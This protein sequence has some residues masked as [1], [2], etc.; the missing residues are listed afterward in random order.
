[1]LCY[2]GDPAWE[3]HFRGTA[4]HNTVRID[5]ADQAL[6]LG[7]MAWSYSYVARAE[8]W[9]PVN[10][11]GAFVGSHDGFTR[12]GGDAVHRRLVWLRPDGY[13]VVCDEIL[14][15]R[16]H[17]AEV[18]FQFAPGTLDLIAHGAARFAD[19]AMV[20]WTD[21]HV[22]HAQVAQGGTRPEDGWIAPSLGVLAPA[23][24]LT[25]SSR[26]APPFARVLTILARPPVA[27]LRPEEE[28]PGVLC[29]RGPD[30]EDRVA[31]TAAGVAITRL[32]HGA[33]SIVAHVGA[34][35]CA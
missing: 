2:N 15:D 26:I 16:E 9:C 20:S 19:T 5:G 32:S 6:H 24:R 23:P 10:G 30:F 7:K 4:A 17:D 14:C 3:A 21:A 25:L 27:D 18:I 11:H 34:G 31:A 22:W 8:R 1:L 33:P 29:V 12:R 28:H 13:L 35:R